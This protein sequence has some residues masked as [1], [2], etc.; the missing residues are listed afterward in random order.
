[1]RPP[2]DCRAVSTSVSRQSSATTIPG[3]G[4]VAL[5]S[6][7]PMLLAVSM[8]IGAGLVADAAP[9]LAV[10]LGLGAFA[11]FLGIVV[12]LW[13]WLLRAGRELEQ[14]T[15]AWVAGDEATMVR[16][17]R[18]A[19]STVF[20]ADMRARAVHLLALAAEQRGD[21]TAAVDLFA[22]AERAL[23]AMAAPV[24]K[25]DARL[26]IGGHRALCLVATGA[27]ATAAG[28][29]DRLVA[30]YGQKGKSG[31]V[32]ALTDDSTWGLGSISANDAMRKLDGG[33]DPRPLISLAFALLHHARG[34]R[35]EVLRVLDAERALL[36]KGLLARE[37][38]LARRLH[39]AASGQDDDAPGADPWSDSILRGCRP[40]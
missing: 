36:D 25:R 5:L 18:R 37:L 35:Q 10:V 11:V 3:R 27:N 40:T 16:L 28:E 17:A 13:V 4:L 15:Q 32:D 20:R 14:A 39:A 12:L 29:L 9:A 6:F 19:L 22:L 8:G 7:G 26:T 23:P 2:L 24:R 34:A 31:L 30:E 21:F 33:R 38:L 1:M